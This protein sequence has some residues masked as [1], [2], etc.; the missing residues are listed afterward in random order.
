MSKFSLEIE[1]D[2]GFYLLGICSHIK[3]YRLCWELNQHLN[4]E[5]RK[6]EDLEI[7]SQGEKK[8]YSF[9]VDEGGEKAND[10]YLISNKSPLGF[11]VPEEKKCDYFLVVKGA[12][13]KDEEK[14]ILKSVNESKNVLTSYPIEAAELK[15]KNNLIF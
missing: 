8:L 11:L 5:L 9:N 13:S 2:F 3:D 15:S 1:E 12:L 10:Y 14:E 4:V 6:S 7:Q